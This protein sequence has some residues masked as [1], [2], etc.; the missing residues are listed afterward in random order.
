MFA[1][2]RKR[3][4][5]TGKH[6]AS[7]SWR[8]TA[9]DAVF[10]FPVAIGSI[11][12]KLEGKTQVVQIERSELLLRLFGHERDTSAA[13]EAVIDDE[14]PK[15]SHGQLSFHTAQLRGV[16]EGQTIFYSCLNE[17]C[18]HKFTVNS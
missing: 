10:L 1:L 8:H 9:S 11:S 13:D 5:A 4:V 18:G 14:C 3:L 7:H 15:C 6:T 2:H 16:D 12:E 17:A